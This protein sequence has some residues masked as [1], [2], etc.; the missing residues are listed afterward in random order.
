MRLLAV[1]DLHLG[2]A[3]NRAILTDLDDHRNDWLILAGDVGESLTHMALAFEALRPRFARLIWV[4][5]NHELWT[6][7]ENGERLG[8]AEKYAALIDLARMYDVL[9]PEDAYPTWS[10]GPERT[11]VVLCPLF[12]LYDY[13]FRPPDVPLEG[14]RKWAAEGHALCA[15]ELRL[16]PAPHAN[17]AAWC[18]QR[19]VISRA[20]LN[21]LPPG[22]R[23]VL[24]NHFPL[25][26]D[27]LFIRKVPRLAP[28]CGTVATDDWHRRYNAMVVVSGH[29]HVPRTDWRDGTRFEEVSLGYPREWHGRF[30]RPRLRDVM[31]EILPGPGGGPVVS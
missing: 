17:R 21:A 12:V 28:W 29:Q 15:D 6:T 5:G 19:V 27:L 20:R 30:D 23:T 18:R 26:K 8:G 3:D 2:H 4:P 16:S 1:S 14:L 22:T 10:D 9:T 11:P 13:S 7:D 31:R 25:R 24:I